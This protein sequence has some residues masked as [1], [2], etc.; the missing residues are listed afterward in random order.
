MSLQR[1]PFNTGYRHSDTLRKSPSSRLNQ[2]NKTIQTTDCR[3]RVPLPPPPSV[4]YKTN[5]NEDRRRFYNSLQ[6]GGTPYL[7]VLVCR[8]SL[9]LYNGVFSATYFMEEGLC[10]P[11]PPRPLSTSFSKDEVVSHFQHSR[12]F[13]EESQGGVSEIVGKDDTSCGTLCVC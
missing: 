5:Q 12:H 6:S 1:F 2:R 8:E 10:A 13:K 3:F 7:L 9:N 4:T 11:P